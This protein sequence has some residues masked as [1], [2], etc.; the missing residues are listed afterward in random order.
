M[1]SY[2]SDRFAPGP[3]YD[4]LTS[5]E[6]LYHQEIGLFS[7]KEGNDGFLSPR[8]CV[9]Q[10]SD[11]PS[12]TQRVLQDVAGHRHPSKKK[13]PGSEK[14]PQRCFH[15]RFNN[16]GGGVLKNNL[17]IRTHQTLC[18]P[19]RPLGEAGRCSV[20]MRVS[21][22][23][24]SLSGTRGRGDDEFSYRGTSAIRTL[25]LEGRAVGVLLI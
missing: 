20:F 23:W 17:K 25:R 14:R 9:D 18:C 7:N 8:I 6:S 21:I 15:V 16:E 5:M 10:K 2:W 22:K 12:E 3:G 24:P 19:F 13:R 11:V 4:S 1:T